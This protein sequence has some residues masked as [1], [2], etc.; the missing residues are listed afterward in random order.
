MK[1]S[2]VDNTFVER[3]IRDIIKCSREDAG[4]AQSILQKRSV[5]DYSYLVFTPLGTALGG[6]WG[7]C[8]GIVG[9]TQERSDPSNGPWGTRTPDIDNDR[10]G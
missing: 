8:R 6:L 10:Q 2:A 9:H 7:A 4:L 3:K 1:D 5:N